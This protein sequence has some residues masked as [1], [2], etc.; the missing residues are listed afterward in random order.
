MGTV[1]QL[2]EMID[3][4][5]DFI[6]D[7][8]QRTFHI[9]AMAGTQAFKIVINCVLS[10]SEFQNICVVEGC[11][12]YY[13]MTK[14]SPCGNHFF[15]ADLIK[16]TKIPDFG[17]SSGFDH[18][19]LIWNPMKIEYKHEVDISY[20]GKFDYMI[21]NDAHLISEDI[22]G[23][24]RK[25]FQGKLILIFDPFEAGAEAFV[26]HPCIMDSLERSSA[27]TAY[28]RSMLGVSTRGI[29]RSVRCSVKDQ[30]IQRRSIGKNDGSQYVTDSKALAIEIWGKQTSS[31]FRKGQ[32]LWVTDK[33]ILRIREPNGRIHT[34]T[35][36]S[37]LTIASVPINT[38]KLKLRL[39]NSNFVFESEVSYEDQPLIGKIMVRPANIIMKD[40]IRYHRY[41]SMTLVANNNLTP[42]ERYLL[43]K[44]T[45][46][47]VVG[48]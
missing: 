10:K 33:R 32:R 37:L 13:E 12:D 29:D 22:L 26:V 23:I 48:I 4:V 35:K 24:I 19:Y 15:Y 45:H 40:E 7:P 38:K 3:L 30:K 39:W 14:P 21:I 34:I 1:L 44:N 2:H 6:S 5:E 27:I 41:T 11:Q 18:G 31:P 46:N 20:V 42:R 43:A 36:D 17:Y 9:G 28:A 25:Y 47:L 8:I 16:E